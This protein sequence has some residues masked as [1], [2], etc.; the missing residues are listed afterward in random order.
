MRLSSKLPARRRGVFLY[1]AAAGSGAQALSSN[2]TGW[3]NTASGAQALYLT[4]IVNI[5]TSKARALPGVKAVLT[6]KW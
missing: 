5:D 1:S 3:F 6:Y 4:R 2:S